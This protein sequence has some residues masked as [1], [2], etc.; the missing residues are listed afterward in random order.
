MTAYPTG[1]FDF[2]KEHNG[3]HPFKRRDRVRVPC[4]GNMRA[5]VK[6]AYWTM[7]AAVTDLRFDEDKSRNVWR[8][9]AER[10]EHLPAVDALGEIA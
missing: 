8:W 2:K 9:K 3:V 6:R 1:T 5:T 7:G 10:I 4:L